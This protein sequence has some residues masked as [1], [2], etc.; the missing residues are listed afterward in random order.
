MAWRIDESVLRGEIDNRTR[1]RVTGRIWFEGLAR[2]VELAL[3]GNAWRDLAGLRLEFVNP[4]A[5]KKPLSA[6]EVAGFAARQ[7]GVV[8]DCTA[9]RR[10]KV[11]EVTMDELMDLYRQRKP[12]PWHWG[13]SLYLEWFSDT[14]GRVV[15]ESASFLLTVSPDIAWDMTP[16][17]EAVQRRKNA[18]AMGGFMQQ[19]GAAVTGED[20][21]E[22]EAFED[23]AW[24][25]QKPQSEAEAEKMQEDSDR[26]ADRI[27][28]RLKREGPDADYEKILAEELGRRAQERGELPPTPQEEAKRAE[29]IDEMNRAAEEAL[30]KP[31]PELEEEVRRKHPLAEKAFEWSVRL[32]KEPEAR[33][34]V[35]LDVGEEHP[36]IELGASAAKA[37]AKLAGALNGPEWPPTVDACGGVIVRLKRAREF[38]DDTLR[39]AEACAEEGLAEGKWL[40][41]VRTE[42]EEMAGECDALIA[43]LRAK[44]ERGCD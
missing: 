23:T 11:P 7:T 30:A 43:E 13:N 25:A 28:A 17:E 2:P 39:A 15:I 8:G 33:G 12:F 19:L 32:M 42:G 4:V 34:W 22:G 35:P 20:G 14:N 6:D 18:K 5:V 40:T 38:L 16:E 24:N 37:G 10:V 41:A 29:W 1:D 21:I 26:L 9:S 36:L 44:L 3:T 27:N 31:D